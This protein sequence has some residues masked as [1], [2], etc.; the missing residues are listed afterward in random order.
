MIHSSGIHGFS[1]RQHAGKA[2]STHHPTP[3][4]PVC[5]GCLAFREVKAVWEQQQEEIQAEQHLLDD[6]VADD[7]EM[8]AVAAPAE[9]TSVADDDENAE[10]E[11]AGG[12]EEY[13]AT[14]DDENLSLGELVAKNSAPP[15]VG[16]I[17]RAAFEVAT[18]LARATGREESA[19]S[20]TPSFAASHLSEPSQPASSEFSDSEAPEDSVAEEVYTAVWN[21]S[22]DSAATAATAAN[23]RITIVSA[24]GGTTE[25]AECMAI[26]R[27]CFAGRGRNDFMDIAAEVE[28]KHKAVL[29]CAKSIDA[30]LG[31]QPVLGYAMVV[32]LT[33]KD[34]TRP[35]K[36]SLA[37]IIKLA[38]APAFRRKGIGNALLLEALNEA[39]VKSD[40]CSLHVDVMDRQS[41]LDMQKNRAPVPRL[42]T[43]HS[44][45]TRPH[46]AHFISK[47]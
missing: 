23:V 41:N 9:S 25:I 28:G 29:L 34:Q 24:A 14:E 1:A 2:S 44:E 6:D 27:V 8:A 21:K 37:V 46:D 47:G 30:P 36:P 19:Q 5:V 11:P 3:R 38:V 15:T 22:A 32:R 33:P 40:V 10:E 17:R 13:E 12:G 26:E 20:P 31:I 39:V 35:V 42:F 16:R 43:P 18:S 7:E 45:I 4:T